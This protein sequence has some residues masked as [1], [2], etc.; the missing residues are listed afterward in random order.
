MP[1]F[2]L[3]NIIA[4][5]IFFVLKKLPFRWHNHLFC[6]G[7]NLFLGPFANALV[8]EVMPMNLLAKDILK[9]SFFFLVFDF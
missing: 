1:L 2:L 7:M 8:Q 3:Q 5:L 9:I 4:F 6:N